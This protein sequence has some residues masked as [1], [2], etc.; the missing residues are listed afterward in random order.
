MII[1][2]RA[3]KANSIISS[4]PSLMAQGKKCD[5]TEC[6]S[7]SGN[8]TYKGHKKACVDGIGSCDSTSCSTP[9]DAGPNPTLVFPK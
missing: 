8:V 5:V 4:Y 1:L 3:S 9:C 2:E 6:E 7:K